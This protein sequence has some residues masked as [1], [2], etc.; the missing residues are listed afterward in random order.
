[1]KYKYKIALIVVYFGE[2]PWFFKYF[3]HSSL[4][5]PS[6]DFFILT[7]NDV[8]FDLPNNIKFIRYNMKQ[9][10]KD[11]SESLCLN[12]NISHG[13]KLCDFKPAYGIIFSKLLKGYDFWGYCDID[14]IWGDIRGFITSDLLNRFDVIS[15]RHDYLT[16]SFTLYRNNNLIKKIFK[17][18]K[19]Y[20]KV[21]TSDRN[22][23]FDETNYAFKKFGDGIHHSMIQTEIE[24]M[25]HIVKRMQENNALKV[26]FDLLILEGLPGSITWGEGKLSYRKT[27]ELMYYHFIALKEIYFENEMQF[28]S[29]PKTFKITKKKITTKY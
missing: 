21:Y 22:F 5:N 23:C 16:G 24:S 27:F 25:T 7:D 2:F 15:A 10:N 14:L 13:Y 1:M 8:L 4:F 17:Q 26:F 12:I 20:K 9:L 6:I 19:D 28:S 29:S 3:L 18:S 11:A